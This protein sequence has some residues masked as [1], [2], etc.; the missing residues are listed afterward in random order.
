MA[1]ISRMDAAQIRKVQTRAMGHNPVTDFVLG[2]VVPG[3][4]ITDRSFDG[5]GGSVPV[6]IY[7][8]ARPGPAL[9]PLV[10]NFHGGGWVLGNLDQSDSICS[11]VSSNVDAIVVSVD[12]RLAPNDP[13]PAA[14]EDC[15]AALEWVAAEAPEMGSDG[16]RIAVMGDSAGGNLAAVVCLLAKERSGPPILHQT[17]IY[18]ATDL[19][20]HSESLETNAD[21]P[22]LSRD[23][24]Q[25]FRTLYLGDLPGAEL[26]HRAS[27]LLAS[28]H[29]SLPPALIQ[30]AEHD[31]IRDDGIRY[32]NELRD[33]G[34]PVRLTEYVGMPHG[35]LSFPWFCRSAPQALAE[36]FAEQVAALF[37]CF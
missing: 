18:P 16:H 23:D 5:P 33:A 15:Y 11:Q 3:V 6:R 36:I 2:A 9:R 30:V 4:T 22:V 27:P 28:D 12:Y 24:V 37:G 17:L 1:S 35:Y 26:D 20:L 29:S 31:P 8:P 7:T 14:P 13:F 34:V 25:A 32:A 21:K 10:L 19:T